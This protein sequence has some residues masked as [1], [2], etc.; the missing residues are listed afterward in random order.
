MGAGPPHMTAGFGAGGVGAG[1]LGSH[2]AVTGSGRLRG[3]PSRLAS[4]AATEPRGP[5][6]P[7]CVC[8]FLRAAR[9]LPPSMT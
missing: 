8:V 9:W 1:H 2:A 3:R 7:R 4:T 6:A 5:G